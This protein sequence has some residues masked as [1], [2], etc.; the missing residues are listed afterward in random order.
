M[1]PQLRIAVIVLAVA[2]AGAGI[3]A[4]RSSPTLHPGENSPAAIE[5]N[6]LSISV[7]QYEKMLTREIKTALSQ[8]GG[9]AMEIDFSS[10]IVQV[11]R[12]QVELQLRER[13]VQQLAIR[14]AARD[15]G[16]EAS[17]DSVQAAWRMMT[18][19]LDDT[20]LENGLRQA[21]LTREEVLEEIKAGLTTELFLNSRV[22]AAIATD[23]EARAFFEENKT[24]FNRPETAR[25]RHILVADDANGARLIREIRAR[26]E[27]GEDFA[28]LAGEFSIDGSAQAGGDL[29]SFERGR[30]VPEFE[31]AVFSLPI[32]KVSQPVK[33]QF[34]W[35]LIRVDARTPARLAD[36]NAERD[37]VVMMAGRRATMTSMQAFV[38]DL[39]EKATVT[40]HLPAVAPPAVPEMPVTP[41]MP[42][43]AAPET[44]PGRP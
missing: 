9:G 12:S 37:T 34:G 35:H 36:F 10:P 2:A 7:A 23:S 4:Y 19:Q 31:K 32:G 18:A 39:Q 5:V 41:D 14:A 20:A 33:T 38:E 17:S 44:P 30:M 22:P 21:N 24:R 43:E 3:Y 16:I 8:M 29:G 13:I 1:N 26:I 11:L 15:A 6:G 27:R 25:A 40:I 42:E 28:V